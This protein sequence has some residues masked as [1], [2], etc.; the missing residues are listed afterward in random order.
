MKRKIGTLISALVIL[1]LQVTPTMSAANINDSA[2]HDASIVEPSNTLAKGGHVLSDW[3]YR[4]DATSIVFTKYKGTS[5]EIEIPGKIN[6]KQVFLEVSGNTIFPINTTSI[7][8]GSLTEKVKVTDR[9]A[10]YLFSKLRNLT[11]LDISG[12]DTSDVVNMSNMF[13]GCSSL[14]SLDVSNLKTQNVTNMSN[15]FYNCG[16]LTSLDVSQFNTSNVTNMLAMF[17]GCNNLTFVD[18]S[19]F[20]TRNVTEMSQMFSFCNSLTSVDVSNF[21]TRNV[22][23]MKFMFYYC[24]NLMHLDVSGFD[25]R[26]VTDMR[27]LFYLCHSLKT[28]DVSNFA[29]HNVEGMYAMFY[30]CS[31]LT[32]LDVSNFDTQKVDEMYMMFYGCSNLTSLDVSSFDTRNVIDMDRMFGGC[33]SLT[34]L[35]VSGF[36]TRN[37]IDMYG[38]FKDCNNVK[39][40]DLENFDLTNTV[41][42]SEMFCVSGDESVP[43][44]IICNDQKILDTYDHTIEGR[45]FAG[46]IYFSK[47]GVFANDQTTMRYFDHFVVTNSNQLIV[48]KEDIIHKY[49]PVKIGASFEGW[50][51]NDTLTQPLELEERVSLA[52][53][54]DTKLYAK[55]IYSN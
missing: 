4:E 44:I 26:N 22:V 41:E 3:E 19:N 21:D 7:V 1:L 45:V 10:S 47:D 52:D 46:P 16:S 27:G 39:I 40:F 38:M 6:G 28:L 29:T 30:G 36:D 43:T 54:I 55:Y 25:T 18:V 8:V 23:D 14:T 2:Y 17:E 15:M 48:P 9:N 12:L 13:N 33:S 24:R 50:Y 49:I 11:S 31:G 34:S 37:V 42:Y 53:L 51:L 32:T 20:D 35:D 5:S